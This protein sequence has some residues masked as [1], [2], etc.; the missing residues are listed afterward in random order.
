MDLVLFFAL[1]FLATA[2]LVRHAPMEALYLHAGLWTGM[3]LVALQCL[4]LGVIVPPRAFTFAW[5][6]YALLLVRADGRRR[7]GQALKGDGA[8]R[9]KLDL[10]GWPETDIFAH[11]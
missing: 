6:V 7:R 8:M 10:I 3:A 5:I 1:F 4:Q 2:V 11:S 9:A